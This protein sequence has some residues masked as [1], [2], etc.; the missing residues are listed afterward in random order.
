MPNS[1]TPSPIAFED[2]A[3][4]CARASSLDLDRARELERF[5]R[6]R[7]QSLVQ[8]FVERGGIDEHELLR[9]LATALDLDFIGEEPRQLAADAM[10]L[11]PATLATRF[12]VFPLGNGD[13]GVLRVA[14][15]NPF[16]LQSWDELKQL[17]AVT[18]E[19]VLCPRTLI[20]RLLKAHYG[21]GAETVERLVAD[22]TADQVQGL[23]P[24]TTDLSEE[25]AANEPTVVGLVNRILT[26]AIR[27][28]ATDIHFE[29]YESRYRVRYRIDGM[30]EE[31]SIPVSVKLLK[32]AMVSRIKIMANLDITEK[33]LPQDGRAHVSLAGDDYDLRI[34][35]LP[36]VF[37]EA[38]NI[39]LQSR[40]M[41]H[42]ELEALGFESQEQQKIAELAD[43]PHGLVLVT[44]PT[45][46]GKTTTLYTCLTKINKPQ[47]KILTIEDPVEYW[48]EDILQI[49]VHEEIGFTFARSLRSMLRHDPDV[50]L[51]TT[52]LQKSFLPT[53]SRSWRT[54]PAVTFGRTRTST[55]RR[56]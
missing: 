13:A 50:M 21:L 41:V 51:V 25:E 12:R 17:L 52:K 55:Q 1:G 4:L 45:G 9:N 5:A 11:I 33:R 28:G 46:S 54:L 35:I 27:N 47:T 34:S 7:S 24:R 3:T 20:D 6:E 38:V 36:G 22:K 43:R 18:L 39:R 44:G 15:S 16:D 31:T 40:Q 56:I 23:T 30:L 49:Q 10:A 26:D 14:C 48:M 42:L 29:P 32:L 8:V 37:G 19:K 2:E 53:R